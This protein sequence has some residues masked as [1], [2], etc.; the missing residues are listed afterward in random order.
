MNPENPPSSAKPKNPKRKSLEK[1]CLDPQAQSRIKEWTIEVN[2]LLK[3]SKFSRSD[4][5]TWI[6]K[7][8]AVSLSSKELKAIK[9]EFFDPAKALMWAANKVREASK[10]GEEIDIEKLIDQTVRTK[11]EAT[12]KVKKPRTRKNA[13]M[14]PKASTSASEVIEP[15]QV[16]ESIGVQRSSGKY[17]R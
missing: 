1:V 13:T 5:V 11:S 9:D 3:G 17:L 8:R 14:K 7:N 4:M 2:N 12:S 16:N 6:I 10:K 15:P